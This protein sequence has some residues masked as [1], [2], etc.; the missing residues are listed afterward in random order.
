M[1]KPL[2]ILVGGYLLRDLRSRRLLMVLTVLG[3]ALGAAVGGSIVMLQRGVTAEFD[4][5]DSTLVSS[6][7]SPI[8][9]VSPD[10]KI[11]VIEGP[12]PDRRSPGVG[13]S[14]PDQCL[15]CHG[16]HRT[17][18]GTCCRCFADWRGRCWRR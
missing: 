8:V 16:D 9:S 10:M 6:L 2:R 17:D 13:A 4:E 14:R 1:V 18:D 5:V 7:I 3:V 11:D 12:R 15:L